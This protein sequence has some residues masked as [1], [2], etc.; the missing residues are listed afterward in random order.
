MDVVEE[1]KTGTFVLK[2]WY[3]WNSATVGRRINRK[4][5][6][7]GY[8]YRSKDQLFLTTDEI[9]YWLGLN[10]RMFR[11]SHFRAGKARYFCWS[12]SRWVLTAGVLTAGGFSQEPHTWSLALTVEGCRIQPFICVTT[13]ALFS[14]PCFLLSLYHCHGWVLLHL[15]IWKKNLSTSP[16]SQ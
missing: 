6:I 7:P 9:L 5:K 8:R 14:S 3:E 4:I 13:S 11:L 16:I 12:L 15:Y 2:L 10:Q 1:K